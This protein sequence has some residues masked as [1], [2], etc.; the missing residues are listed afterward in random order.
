MKRNFKV[1]KQDKNLSHLSDADIEKLY[2]TYIEMDGK[3]QNFKGSKREYCSIISGMIKNWLKSVNKNGLSGG[4]GTRKGIIKKKI[5]IE[6]DIEKISEKVKDLSGKIDEANNFIAKTY[7]NNK[8]KI[9][10]ANNPKITK[11]MKN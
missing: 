1:I 6:K 9:A 5:P 4:K 3:H 7:A 8:K 10:T 11:K 2:S